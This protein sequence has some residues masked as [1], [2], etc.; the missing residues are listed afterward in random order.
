MTWLVLAVF[1][2]VVLGLLAAKL[3]SSQRE[4]DGS[5]YEAR[6]HFFSPAE[7]SFLGVL[8]QAVADQYRVFG[9]VRVADVV[10]AKSSL[11]RTDWQRT[12]NRIK[13]KH[14]DFVLCAK[15]DLRVVCVI[16]LN[17]QSHKRRDRQDR[18]SFLSEIC[19]DIS[20]PLLQMPAKQA[21]SITDV[22][23]AV[24]Q[25]VTGAR[26]RAA[27]PPRIEPAGRAAE[28]HAQTDTSAAPVSANTRQAAP[29]PACPKCGAPMALRT[30]RAGGARFWGCSSYPSC[31]G[32]V[33]ATA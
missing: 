11:T 17:D 31:R 2:V 24:L 23:A 14:F 22:R 15:Q 1:V 21:Y 16:E 26:V 7:R 20:L 19:R 5:P 9:K 8:D 29:T 33:A 25:A 28:P 27:K 3:A 18:D 4:G 6:E 10:E 12:F 32:F 30:A 13:A